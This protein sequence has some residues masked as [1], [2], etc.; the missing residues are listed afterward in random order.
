MTEEE[1]KQLQVG[2][3]LKESGYNTIVMVE[4]V[5]DR[6]VVMILKDHEKYGAHRHF[7]DFAGLQTYTKIE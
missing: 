4:S 3:L 2:D 1:A 6:G 5:K 7:L